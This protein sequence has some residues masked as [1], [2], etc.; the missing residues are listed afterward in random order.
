VKTTA[1]DVPENTMNKPAEDVAS[2]LRKHN[3]KR[4]PGS[5][6]R[7]IQFYINRAGHSLSAQR[8][9]TLKQAMAIIRD[10]K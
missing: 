9:K 7:Y 1:I 6:N 4:T 5:I 10:S 8:K 2:V 3:K